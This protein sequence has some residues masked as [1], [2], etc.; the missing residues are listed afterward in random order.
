MH[1]SVAGTVSDGAVTE[2]SSGSYNG[3]FPDLSSVLGALATYGNTFG[4][5]TPD[6][7]AVLDGATGES[8]SRT[9]SHNIPHKPT[10]SEPH[11]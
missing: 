2:G 1:I 8:S 5:N 3:S 9:S 6:G 10:F 11:S 7:P 4:G